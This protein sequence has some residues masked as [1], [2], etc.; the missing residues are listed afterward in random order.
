MKCS[1]VLDTGLEPVTSA[2]SRRHSKPT[3]LIEQEIRNARYKDWRNCLR[4]RYKT[5]FIILLFYRP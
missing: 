2:L 3:E 5:Y 1:I 4:F